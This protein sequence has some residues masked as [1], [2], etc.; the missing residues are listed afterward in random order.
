MFTT[1][2]GIP[3]IKVWETHLAEHPKHISLGDKLVPVR[4]PYR[5][6]PCKV[7]KI[8]WREELYKGVPMRFYSFYCNKVR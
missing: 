7:V 2:I 4:G 3:D 1:A 5:G 8:E 6:V